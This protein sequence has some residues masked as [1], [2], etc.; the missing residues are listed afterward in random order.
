MFKTGPEVKEKIEDIQIKENIR[1]PE[2]EIQTL[3][4]KIIDMLLV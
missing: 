3:D 2:Q 4:L 1:I